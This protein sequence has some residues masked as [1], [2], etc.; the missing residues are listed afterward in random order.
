MS[1]D[2]AEES[3]TQQLEAARPGLLQFVTLSGTHDPEDLVQ[4]T[5]EIAWQ[6]R[7]SFEG[8]AALRTWLYGIARNVTRNE[9]RKNA[10]LSVDPETLDGPAQAR[11]VFTSVVRRELAERLELAV[12][13]LPSVLAEAFVLH[14]LVQLPFGEIA[15]IVECSE[16]TAR[17]RAHRARKLLQGELGDWEDGI[18][19]PGSDRV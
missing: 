6:Q 17:V 8:K 3:F 13:R 14:H 16:A 15:E 2:P 9:R 7:G 11:G 12:G 18:R 19:S 5:L 1:R 4:R 10:P